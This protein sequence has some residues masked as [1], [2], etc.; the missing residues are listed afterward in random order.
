MSLPPEGQTALSSVIASV[1]VPTRTSDLFSMTKLIANSHVKSVS[2]KFALL[3]IF[4]CSECEL[5]LKQ[6]P[7]PAL[8]YFLITSWSG[9]HQD[10]PL[11][12]VKIV[13]VQTPPRPQ[14]V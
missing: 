5:S 4:K 3:H 12:T 6:P 14:V 11:F 10:A 7:R 8:M 1:S 13:C 9:T 2:V